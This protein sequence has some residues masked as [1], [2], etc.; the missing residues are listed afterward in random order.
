MLTINTLEIV[1]KTYERKK[2]VYELN[3][4][5]F[6]EHLE[7]MSGRPKRKQSSNGNVIFVNIC[8]TG[9]EKI[10]RKKSKGNSQLKNKQFSTKK[11]QNH[12]KVINK[13]CRL[14]RIDYIF[15]YS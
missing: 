12:T 3:D 13:V 1:N 4:G 8:S 6:I 15:S 14:Q 7:A 2:N 10:A 5:V 11:A 9:K